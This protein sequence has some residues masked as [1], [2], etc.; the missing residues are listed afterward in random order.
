MGIFRIPV[1]QFFS[2]LATSEVTGR[3]GWKPSLRRCLHVW[4][5]LIWGCPKRWG[6]LPTMDG[7]LQGKS[8]SKMDDDWGHPHDPGNPLGCLYPS[9]QV[10][11]CTIFTRRA[12]TTPLDHW[13]CP[14]PWTI[15][16]SWTHATHAPRKTEGGNL[17]QRTSVSLDI[18]SKH[19]NL[20][21][22]TSCSIAAA[23]NTC[24]YSFGHRMR[25][26]DGYTHSNYQTDAEHVWT[27]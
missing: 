24:M 20:E 21:I 16:A 9:Q 25:D 11:T 18:E 6:G 5:C 19:K 17:V 27:C 10:S 13:R 22:Y 12:K 26:S 1:N 7:V 14:R 2:W 23:M 15:G 8:E 3:A 4:S